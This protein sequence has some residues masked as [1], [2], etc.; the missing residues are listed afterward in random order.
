M[1]T[2]R[3]HQARIVDQTRAEVAK[4]HHRVLT[5]LP[6]GGGKTYILADIARR[7]VEKGNRVLCLMH[8]RHLVDQMAARFNDYGLDVGVIMAGSDT[9]LSQPI[10]IATIQTY[11]R[12]IKLDENG[13]RP[14]F[15]DADVVLIDEAHRSLSRIYQEVLE[16]YA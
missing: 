6:T 9:D 15:I 10:Q 12:R 5:V 4:G 13:R 7:A 3:D 16:L 11:H 1:I 14:F 8:R 2:L